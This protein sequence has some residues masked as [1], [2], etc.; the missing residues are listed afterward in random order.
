MES[1]LRLSHDLAA[2]VIFAAFGVFFLYFGWNYPVG[3]AVRMGP[4]YLPMVLG[5]A[6]VALGSGLVLRGTIAPGD[7]PGDHIDGFAVRPVLFICGTFLLFAALI[8]HLGLPAVAIATTLC[9]ALASRGFRLREQLILGVVAA[10]ATSLLFVVALELPIR[11]WPAW[12]D[13]VVYR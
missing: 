3:S 2:G 12:L 9:A 13:A 1:R 10:V 5:W 6:L 11:L 4:G 8:E 7:R